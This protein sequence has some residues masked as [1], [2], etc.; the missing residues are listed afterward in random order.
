M[1]YVLA[2]LMVLFP[3]LAQAQNGPQ[4]TCTTV[5]P[6]VTAGAYTSGQDIG[7]KLTFTG[8][9]RNTTRAGMLVS[10]S[11]V[12]QNAQAQDLELVIFNDNPSATT[13]TDNATLDIA[14]GDMAKIAGV[15]SLGSTTRFAYADNGVKFIGSLAIPVQGGQASGTASRTLY[16]ALVSRGTPTFA[17]TTD[18]SVMICVSQD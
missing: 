2:A 10:V 17:A 11:V 13:F 7:G 18:V 4:T 15:I 9:L 8:A 6:T 12:D 14:D 1:K 16:G 3:A 5:T